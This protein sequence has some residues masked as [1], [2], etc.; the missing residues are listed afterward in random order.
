V[1]DGDRRQG[2][3]RRRLS[4]SPPV[5][6]G[7]RVDMVFGK[8]KAAEPRVEVVDWR[9]VREFRLTETV[10][11]KGKGRRKPEVGRLAVRVPTGDPEDPLLAPCAFF[12]PH[13]AAPVAASRVY[14]DEDAREV[15]LSV[16]KRKQP[17]GEV[18]HLVSDE[19]GAEVGLIRRIPPATRLHRHNWRMAQ[20]GRPEI[21]AHHVRPRQRQGIVMDALGSALGASAGEGGDFA[22]LARTLEWRA[23]EEHVMTSRTFDA[24]VIEADWL[25]RRLAI[26]FAMLLDR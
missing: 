14:R 22:K 4:T 23:D 1:H 2:T 26:A 8:R 25:D 3:Q 11:P 6:S 9:G 18:R 10:R 19:D 13:V 21:V 12:A 17:D 5:R 20:G 15:L 7:Y 16:E 24:V